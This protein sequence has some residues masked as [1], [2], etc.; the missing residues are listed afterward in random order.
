LF[1]R[2]FHVNH[3]ANALN[4]LALNACVR[5]GILSHF[6]C[7]NLNEIVLVL[8]VAYALMAAAPETISDNSLV[9]AA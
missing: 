1:T 9:I 4:N 2:K 8:A 3:S 6:F 5:F 7:S